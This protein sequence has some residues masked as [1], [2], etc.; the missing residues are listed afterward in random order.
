MQVVVVK[1][2]DPT[3]YDLWDTLDEIDKSCYNYCY[4]CG[5][6]LEENEKVVKVGA[7]VDEARHQGRS[8]VVIPAGCVREVS[9]IKEVDWNR[10]GE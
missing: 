9:V 7:I 1:F 3:F 10:P 4:A 5:W 2:A 8:W 6:L